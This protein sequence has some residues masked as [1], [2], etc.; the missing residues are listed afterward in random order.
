MAGTLD[1]DGFSDVLESLPAVAARAMQ[2]RKMPDLEARLRAC[3]RG[4]SVRRAALFLLL[5]LDTEMVTGLLP[6]L[7]DVG[8]GHRDAVLVR[9]VIGRVPRAELE[10]TLPRVV[11]Q[12]LSLAD[13]D[14]VRRLVEL[15]AH[16]G[17]SE[18]L[19]E[20]VNHALA[21]SDPDLQE[22][23]RDFSRR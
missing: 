9:Q 5:F 19:D 6:E 4:T 7:V 3:L 18:C 11:K 20:V 13:A 22:V 14:E 2:L 8:L 17:L 23:G 10:A 16:L 1:D 15:L 21:Q 12:R